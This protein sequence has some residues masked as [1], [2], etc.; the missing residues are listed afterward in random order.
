MIHKITSSV[1]YNYWLKRLCTQLN[2]PTNQNLIKVPKVVKSTNKKGYYKTLGTTVIKSP[3]SPYH[4]LKNNQI[5]IN[6]MCSSS[7]TKSCKT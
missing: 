6:L 2:D 3:I 5:F 4:H 7:L 1:D